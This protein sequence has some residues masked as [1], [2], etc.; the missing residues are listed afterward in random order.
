M[1]D[2]NSKYNAELGSIIHQDKTGQRLA[3]PD[4][5]SPTNGV[6]FHQFGNV[7]H[8]PI[9][10][11]QPPRPDIVPP[12]DDEEATQFIVYYAF[13]VRNSV[14]DDIYVGGH[15]EQ[16]VFITSVQRDEV[17]SAQFVDASHAILSESVTANPSEVKLSLFTVKT[18]GV[19]ITGS[20]S[21]SLSPNSLTS[22]ITGSGINKFLGTGRVV[23]EASIISKSFRADR[24]GLFSGCGVSPADWDLYVQNDTG[25]GGPDLGPS[26]TAG[27][28]FPG[29]DGTETLR[30]MWVRGGVSIASTSLAGPPSCPNPSFSGSGTMSY[31]FAQDG[32]RVQRQYE[33]YLAAD[34][35]VTEPI[36]VV[37]RIIDGRATVNNPSDVTTIDTPYFTKVTAYDLQ[38]NILAENDYEQGNPAISIATPVLPQLA[39]DWRE[40]FDHEPVTVATSFETAVRGTL[41]DPVKQLRRKNLFYSFTSQFQ[42]GSTGNASPAVGSPIGTQITLEDV[43]TFDTDGVFIEL[44]ELPNSTVWAIG[45]SDRVWSAAITLATVDA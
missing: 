30:D 2:G 17:P 14:T 4:T 15:Q 28:N 19:G 42:F 24:I 43:P 8:G 35:T 25:G 21:I 20:G 33:V 9:V 27:V 11:N 39:G 18:N 26:G 31:S 3:T 5:T 41:S 16:P 38:G 12:P 40:L 23:Q 37:R 44:A 45:P 29:I 1:L 36:V 6:A 34:E 10:R 7:W 13:V 32:G 22:A